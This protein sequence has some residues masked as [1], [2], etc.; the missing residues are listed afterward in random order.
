[1]SAVGLAEIPAYLPPFLLRPTRVMTRW[2]A[3]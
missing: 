1:M 3:A 2:A